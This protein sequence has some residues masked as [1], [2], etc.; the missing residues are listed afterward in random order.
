MEDLKYVEARNLLIPHAERY[1]NKK[2][3]KK[4]WTD[5]DTW[6]IAWNRTFLGEMDRLAKEGGIIC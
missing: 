4:P 2:I 5:R 6:I 3:G 1:A